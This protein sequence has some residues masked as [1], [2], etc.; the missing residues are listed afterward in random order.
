MRNIHVAGIV[1]SLGY[2]ISGCGARSSSGDYFGGDSG[3]GAGGSAQDDDCCTPHAS[4]ACS[5]H[6]LAA[7]V[8]N[9]DLSCCTERWTSECVDAVS[10]TGCG[11]CKAGGAGGS[12]GGR[13]SGGAEPG[14]G[15]SSGGAEP[16]GGGSSGGAEPGG[17]G[18]TGGRSSGGAEPGGSGPS[19]GA[20]PGGGGSSG[21]AG[22][23]DCC[24]AHSGT[25]CSDMEVTSCTCQGDRYCCNIAWDNQCVARAERDCD[26]E[27]GAGGIGGSGTG[28]A[29][30]IGG[31]GNGGGTGTCDVVIPSTCRD[32]VCGSCEAAYDTCA[33]DIGCILI[34]ACVAAT[35]CTG[36]DCFSEASCRDVI[37]SNLRSLRATVDLVAC[38]QSNMCSCR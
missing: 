20:E 5:N 27:C 25:G 7:C 35:G 22:P 9:S 26:A 1:F 33:N 34:F 15:G 32:C 16:G 2:L 6:K 14:G 21:G 37:D 4:A 11:T 17:G 28:G 30:P 31:S 3:P 12:T 29:S 24:I 8:C 38:A 10:E 13:S 36:T 18:L 23:A 19:G